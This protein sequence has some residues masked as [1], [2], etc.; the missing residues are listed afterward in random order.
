QAK[1]LRIGDSVARLG[2]IDVRADRLTGTGELDAPGD[3]G[4]HIIN[5]GPSFLTLGKLEIASDA[6]GRLVFNG[7]EV[8]DNADIA[9]INRGAG[10]AAF[11]RIVTAEAGSDAPAILVENRFN[12][13]DDADATRAIGAGVAPVAPD[14]VLTDA[15][16]NLRGLVGIHSEA[17]GIRLEQT[18]SIAANSVEVQALNGD[19]VQSYTDSFTHVA[20]SPLKEV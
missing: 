12:P 20:T 17:G 6:G 7:V 19:F 9:A 15:I 4:I 2:D 1:F 5:E 8:R 10:A 13:L 3:A 18:A 14:I 16:T 11:A